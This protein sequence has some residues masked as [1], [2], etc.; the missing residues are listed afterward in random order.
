M[1]E[2]AR[3]ALTVIAD[4][5]GKLVCDDGSLFDVE[6]YSRFKYGNIRIARE[7]AV[8][9]AR[10]FIESFPDLATSDSRVLIT[11]PSY[12][13][14]GT[15]AQGIVASFLTILNTYRVV[16]GLEPAMP[17]QVVRSFVGK[18]TY[19]MSSAADRLNV[20]AKGDRFVDKT[21]VQ[22]AVVVVIDDVRISGATEKRM[23]ERLM[24]CDPKS[25]CYLHIAR[26]ND[27]QGQTQSRL[28]DTMNKSVQ[29]TLE[30]IEESIEQDEFRLSSRVFEYVMKCPDSEAFYAFLN[31]RSDAFIEEAYAALVNGTS[32]FYHR[33]PEGTAVLERVARERKLPA[34]V[35]MTSLLV[36]NTN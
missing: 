33:S 4:H 28:E 14:L 25:I 24:V 9:L 20:L 1:T 10:H 26:L 18:D 5:G 13:Y 36:Q 23:H 2:I 8:K 16:N 35:F 15:A 7:Y 3:S 22:N 27:A 30:T 21:L 6:A 32:E 29:T 12:K 17:L 31:R 11:G 34:T 19:A